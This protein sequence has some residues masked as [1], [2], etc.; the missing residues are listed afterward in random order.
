MHKHGRVT[1][2]RIDA[3]VCFER[4]HRAAGAP[5]ISLGGGLLPGYLQKM[6]GVWLPF[7]PLNTVPHVGQLLLNH[8]SPD[9]MRMIKQKH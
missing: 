9:H 5:I 7:A 3:E 4:I 8:T 1:G 2:A 6:Q